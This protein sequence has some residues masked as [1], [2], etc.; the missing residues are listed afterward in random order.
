MLQARGP[1]AAR[2]ARAVASLLPPCLVVCH[3]TAV[4]CALFDS[5][6]YKR[7]EWHTLDK[8]ALPRALA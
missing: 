4:S 7:A 2:R 3:A 1:A 5:Y 8:A 6:T